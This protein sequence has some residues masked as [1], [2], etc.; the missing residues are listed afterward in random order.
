MQILDTYANGVL[1]VLGLVV[2]S[3]RRVKACRRRLGPPGGPSA[4]DSHAHNTVCDGGWLRDA[5]S[6]RE[7][8]TPSAQLEDTIAGSRHELRTQHRELR[9][10]EDTTQ[11]DLSTNV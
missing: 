2:D 7:V 1:C 8:H 3:L 5:L 10:A 11:N 9:A 4:A 6:W